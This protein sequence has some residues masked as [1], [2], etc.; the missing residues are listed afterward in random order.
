MSDDKKKPEFTQSITMH[1]NG[2]GN[3]SELHYMIKRDGKET[4]IIRRRRTN[5]SPKYLITVDDFHCG[6]H[7]FNNLQARGK[8]LLE[9]CIAHSE[10]EQ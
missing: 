7:T 4:K 1:I 3:F 6:E 5:G 10:E 8:G 2:G 9:W